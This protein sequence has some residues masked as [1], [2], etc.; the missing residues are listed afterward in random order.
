MF[1]F[2]AQLV[3]YS[4]RSVTGSNPA[5]ALVFLGFLFP[6]TSMIIL[7]FHLQLQFKYQLFQY[8][9]SCINTLFTLFSITSGEALKYGTSGWFRGGARNA[10]ASPLFCAKKEE[11]TEGREA[12][13]ASKIEP[14][15]LLSW[16][17]GFAT[18]YAKIV[19]SLSLWT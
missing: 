11:M 6:I 15:P 10:R 19:I 9:T 13:W 1:D 14:G 16:K 8:L 17:S 3:E 5:E 4:R 18:G 12:G 7:N 2:I